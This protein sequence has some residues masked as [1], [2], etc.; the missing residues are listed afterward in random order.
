[1]TRRGRAAFIGVDLG[2]YGKPSGLALLQWV[3]RGLRLCDVIRKQDDAEILGWIAESAGTGTVVVAVDAPIIIRNEKGIRPAE[4]AL[5][6]QFSRFHAG[7]HAANLGRPFAQHV[8]RFSSALVEM[9]FA[10]NPRMGTQEPGRFQIEVHPHA[11]SVSLFGLQRIVKYKRGKRKERANELNRFRGLL[12]NHLA[13][14][15]P[16]VRDLNLPEVPETGGTK[17]VEDRLDAVLCAYIA[18]Y[19]WYWGLRRN[20]IFGDLETGFIVVPRLKR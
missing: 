3:G 18:A 7:C 4:R 20:T 2:W 16:E 8:M 11:A 5:N 12:L 17:E 14:L 9:G 10:F 15:E 13:K 19:W 1:M 6:A